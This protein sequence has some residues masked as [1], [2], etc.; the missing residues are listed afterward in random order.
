MRLPDGFQRRQDPTAVAAWARKL[1]ARGPTR[2]RQ[3]S[4]ARQAYVPEQFTPL[5]VARIGRVM[6]AGCRV[7]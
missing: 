1:T 2:Q 6:L 4:S 3:S 5:V 7:G